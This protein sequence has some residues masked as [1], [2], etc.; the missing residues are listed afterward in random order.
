MPVTVV[1][2]VGLGPSLLANHGLNWQTAGYLVTHIGSIREAIVHIRDGNF[3]LVLLGRS[4]PA[5]SRERLTFLIRASNSRI[6]VVCISDSAS[7][8]F[9]FA[10]ATIRD[11]PNKLLKDVGEIMVKRAKG[12]AATDAMAG[13]PT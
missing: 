4:I 12:P 8:C 3:D 13:N 5:D 9:S 10:D 2:A 6:P 7:D 1:L 11:E